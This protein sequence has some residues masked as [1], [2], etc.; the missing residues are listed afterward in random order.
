MSASQAAPPRSCP[1][2]R[3]QVFIERDFHGTYGTCI[4]CGFVHDVLLRPPVDLAAE[5]AAMPPRLRRR[6]PSHASLRL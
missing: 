4:S 5:E 2:C 6:Q 3:G 1:R